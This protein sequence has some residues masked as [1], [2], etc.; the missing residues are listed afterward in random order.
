MGRVW[1]QLLAVRARQGLALTDVHMQLVRTPVADD[2]PAQ[3][4]RARARAW[5]CSSCLPGRA[6][7]VQQELLR[8]RGARSRVAQRAPLPRA[9]TA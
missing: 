1:A 6:L 4:V 3:Q 7:C 2:T 5:H 8:R 9:R